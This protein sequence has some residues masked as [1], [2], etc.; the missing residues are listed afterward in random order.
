MF[1]SDPFSD[2][3][4]KIGNHFIQFQFVVD[5]E[6]YFSYNKKLNIDLILLARVHKSFL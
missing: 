1:Y 6:I 4:I 3:T 2:T 5:L